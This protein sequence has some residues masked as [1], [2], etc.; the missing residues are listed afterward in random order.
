MTAKL[1]P[2]KC[3]EPL[4]IYKHNRK[5]VRLTLLTCYTNTI[6]STLFEVN[7]YDYY[8]NETVATGVRL[9]Q[10]FD[11]FEFTNK[12]SLQS[13]MIFIDN[14]AKDRVKTGEWK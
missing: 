6:V 4:A 8:T 10:L 14:F 1:E 11:E 9:D 13:L 5:L 7:A 12:E 3:K 2:I